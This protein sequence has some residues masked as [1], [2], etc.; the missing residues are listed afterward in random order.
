[1]RSEGTVTVILTIGKRGNNPAIRLPK[2]FCE[3]LGIGIGDDMRMSIE[4]DRRIVIELSCDNRT[5]KERMYSWTDVRYRSDELDWG[6]A[7]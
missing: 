1:M 2:S 4:N 3:T 7:A 6:G 5:L